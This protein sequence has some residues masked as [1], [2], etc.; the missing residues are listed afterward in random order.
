MPVF[1]LRGGRRRDELASWCTWAAAAVGGAGLIIVEAT[2]VEAR[3]RIS[4]RDLGLWNED[5]ARRSRPDRRVHDRARRR[6]RDPTG[7][8]GT[9]GRGAQAPLRRAQSLSKRWRRRRRWG[10]G[11]RGGRC[12]VRAVDEAGGAGRIPGSG[13][14]RRAR[15]FAARVPIADLEPP[16]GRVRRQP[17]EPQPD[18]C[19]GSHRRCGAFWPT[20]PATFRPYQ[21]D[22]L[23]RGRLGHRRERRTGAD[24]WTSSAWT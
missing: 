6:A 20:A 7:A 12:R 16:D 9:E 23:D 21:R 10:G 1:R 8:C 15:L 22:G 4:A 13:V 18:C 17:G 24:A 5:Q 19:A 2:A 3:G 14:A 11:D